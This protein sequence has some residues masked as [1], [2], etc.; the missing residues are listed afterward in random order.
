MK[1]SIM[2]LPEEL[3]RKVIFLLPSSDVKNVTAV[4]KRLKDV[5]SEAKLWRNFQLCIN[6]RNIEMATNMLTSERLQ[7]VKSVKFLSWFVPRNKASAVLKELSENNDI[8]ELLVR[9]NDLTSVDPDLLSTC[10]NKKRRVLLTQTKLTKEQVLVIF[11][12]MNKDTSLVELDIRDNDL[13]NVKPDVLSKCINSL[14]KVNL[15]NTHLSWLQKQMMI[16]QMQKKTTL[17]YLDISRNGV[18]NGDIV[19]EGVEVKY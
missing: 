9:G 14:K 12:D 6:Y 1:N 5:G 13:S 3:L 17:E 10:I 18:G 11:E 16:K 4:C 19:V 8:E 7:G 15:T 2:S